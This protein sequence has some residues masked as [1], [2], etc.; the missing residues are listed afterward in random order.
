VKAVSGRCRW[1]LQPGVGRNA[2]PG[3]LSVTTT[4]C[5]GKP[6]V[7]TY[8]VRACLAPAG[9]MLGY[10]LAKVGDPEAVYDLDTTADP[11]SCTCNDFLFRRENRDAKGCRHVAG[12]RAAL[13]ALETF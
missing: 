13:A 9:E 1:L 8:L 2:H 12:L 5:N 10:Q 7:G 11:W 6:I 4:D 3:V